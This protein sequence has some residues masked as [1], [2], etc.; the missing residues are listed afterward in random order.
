[1]KYNYDELFSL[2]NLQYKEIKDVMEEAQKALE[3]IEFNRHLLDRHIQIT[4]RLQEIKTRL[5][6]IDSRTEEIKGDQRLVSLGMQAR[7]EAQGNPPV[8]DAVQ[9]R[10]PV[11][12]NKGVQEN[13]SSNGSMHENNNSTHSTVP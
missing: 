5:E 13:G 11:V 7:N 10:P 6:V 9:T 1:M 2:F 8:K 3:T 12:N 4:L